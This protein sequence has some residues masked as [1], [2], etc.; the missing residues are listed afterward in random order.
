MG[1]LSSVVVVVVCCFFLLLQVSGSL[2][3]LKEFSVSCS[4]C[5]WKLIL[6]CNCSS[7]DE[8]GPEPG[9]GP[10]LGVIW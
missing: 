7:T 10:E 1:K 9:P 8:P 6:Y 5:F 2:H 3:P 4:E